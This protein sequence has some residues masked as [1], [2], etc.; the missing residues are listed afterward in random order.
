MDDARQL[1]VGM[2]DP[3]TG[4]E[5]MVNGLDILCMPARELR[6]REQ[7]FGPNVEVGTQLNSNFPSRYKMSPNQI[8]AVGRGTYTLT[9]LTAIWYNRA[10]AADGLNLSASNAKEYWWVG[11]FKKAFYWMEN[12]PMTPWQAS[13]SELYMKDRGLVAIYGANYRG[14]AYAKQPRYAVRNKN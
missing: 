2:T 12:W 9:P 4:R 13:A 11:D 14:V 1:F 10:T 5:I 3:A 6:F 8:N 7:L